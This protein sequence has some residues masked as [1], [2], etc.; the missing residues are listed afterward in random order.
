VAKALE[1]P[2]SDPTYLEF[3]GFTRP[4]FARLSKP[5]QIFHTEQYSLLMAH[6]AAATEQSDC[7]VVVCGADGSGKTTLLNRY[8]TSLGEDVC[9]ATI[10]ETCKGEKQFYTTFLR[11]LGF[12]EITGTE[13][14]LWRITK[15]FLVHRGM[16]GEP[17]LMMID[18]AHLISPNVLE[19]LRRMSAIK[20]NNQRVLSIVLAGTSDLDRI[21]DSPAMSQLK[22]A[23][24]VHFNIRV[25]T[26]EETANY[27][28]H[29]L[30]LAGGSDVVSFS[31]DAHPLIYRYTGGIPKLINTLCNDLLTEAHSKK[32]HEITEEL[33]RNVADD[34]KLLPHVVPLQGKGRRKTDAD[35]KLMQP[36]EAT[37]ER[38]TPR[39]SAAKRTAEKPKV[40]PKATSAA[41]SNLLE[42][43]SELSNQVGE[44]R[45]DRM[46]A[47]EDIGVRDKENTE[48][49]ARLE[50]QNAENETL[51]DTIN[52]NSKEIERLEK[53][54]ADSE[55]ALT[56]IER[57]SKK[58]Y[59]D[60]NKERKAAQEADKAASTKLAS[61]IEDY[62]AEIAQ[63]KKALSDS[64][65]AL[66]KSEK[67]SDKLTADLQKQR[68]AANAAEA[69]T[70][71]AKT[72]IEKLK[73]KNSEQEQDIKTLKAELNEAQQRD[74]AKLEE[75]IQKK[76]EELA[77][78]AEELES[79]DES[80][81]DLERQFKEIQKE[82][83]SLRLRV[84]ARKT[85]E[86]S[87]SEK[88]LRIADLQAQLDSQSE[89][90]EKLKKKGK[91]GKKDDGAESQAEQIETLETELDEARK[92]L[93]GIQEA[94]TGS[95]EALDEA[96]I[97]LD[98]EEP[99]IQFEED[100]EPQV[101]FE[102]SD[103]PKLLF[104]DGEESV[105]QLEID[106]DAESQ[107]EVEEIELDAGVSEIFMESAADK[108]AA[109]SEETIS[110][111][112]KK[113]RKKEAEEPSEDVAIVALEVFRNGESRQVFKIP[114]GGA[115]V[116]IGRS[117]DSELRLKSEFV[118]R[119]HALI[120]CGNDG[121][122]I[123]DLNSFNG[124][125][126]NSK[127]IS[128]HKLLPTDTIMIGKF[129]IKPKKL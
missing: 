49:R 108:V 9:F 54:L 42:Q 77:A 47:L 78:I 28:W 35:F 104:E 52:E 37:G 64:M 125:L 15:E 55:N 95:E 98:Y 32:L 4:P 50:A 80:I 113:S 39:D 71:K 123:E 60:L 112:R 110:A 2:A 81:N 29:R 14:E 126:I 5:S 7:L 11:Q 13:R 96:D 85:L 20:V 114:E 31:N 38:I 17:V 61:T 21:M 87:V 94:L 68:K 57:E 75:E 106:K 6:L 56:K 119:H 101:E 115:R 121:I 76:D 129:E 99:K 18:N 103:E 89:E 51:A 128:R 82:C 70:S 122:Y 92:M 43:I 30:R 67:A 36:D 118:S 97:E 109:E 24:Q 65:K 40:R 34:R 25:Y 59:S 66:Q 58:L 102:T 91:S 105:V 62:D 100:D 12:S 93:T 1:T 83:A 19:Q 73:D 69:D 79:R 48:L 72:E 86:E 27:V 16:A 22:F 23:S 88:E 3:F 26:E 107:I 116:M 41:D 8:I 127:K 10:D 84:A 120:V 63:L 117:E 111:P 53:A 124:T 46:Q 90:I 33:V 45:T 74:T 44:L